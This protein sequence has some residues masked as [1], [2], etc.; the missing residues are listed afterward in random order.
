[1]I[2]GDYYA[3][4]AS[5]H[6]MLIVPDTGLHDVDELEA[7][8]KEVNETQIAP[9]EILSDKVQHYDNKEHVLE[10]ARSFE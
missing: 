9:D 7:M 10:N 8:V 5:I 3:L 6:E 2:S 4:P 1:M